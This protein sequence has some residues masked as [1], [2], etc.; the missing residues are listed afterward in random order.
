ML[1]PLYLRSITIVWGAKAWQLWVMCCFSFPLPTFN[2]LSNPVSPASTG[3]YLL[4]GFSWYLWL[5]SS[6]CFLLLDYGSDFL[7]TYLFPAFPFSPTIRISFRV[8]T[9]HRP[10]WNIR[11]YTRPASEGLVP[12]LV[13]CNEALISPQNLDQLIPYVLLCS[14]LPRFPAF[15]YL[16]LCLIVLFFCW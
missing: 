2:Q 16:Q 11:N 7:L 14:L 9:I 5:D 15:Y 6:L 1:W 8:L 10:T 13:L 3:G 4:L 12:C